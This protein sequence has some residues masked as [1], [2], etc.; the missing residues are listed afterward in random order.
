MA[1]LVEVEDHRL[2][3]VRLRDEP[4]R[5]RAGDAVGVGKA[6]DEDEDPLP[7]VG[8]EDADE[9]LGTGPRP[10]ESTVARRERLDE[11]PVLG[12]R[13]RR[14]RRTAGHHEAANVCPTTP[15]VNRSRGAG[16]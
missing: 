14:R 3:P 5:H 1:D 6:A 11:P 10:G 16:P 2:H 15:G 13:A 8:L 9:L 7:P 4:E 12:L